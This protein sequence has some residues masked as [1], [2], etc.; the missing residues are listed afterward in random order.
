MSK[1]LIAILKKSREYVKQANHEAECLHDTPDADTYMDG[2]QY[3]I[4]QE[5]ESLLKEIDSAL[6]I[7]EG[8]S[9]G[10]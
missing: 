1:K 8:L 6:A 3:E 2:G 9:V 7:T 10:H 4:M 5:T